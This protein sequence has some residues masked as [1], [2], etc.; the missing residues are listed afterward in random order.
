MD[1]YSVC[2]PEVVHY[3]F[4][5][6]SRGPFAVVATQTANMIA[7]VLTGSVY[8]ILGGFLGQFTPRIGLGIYTAIHIL[9]LVIMTIL[10]FFANYIF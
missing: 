3:F 7:W 9:A 5:A 10:T 6:L 1:P 2:L 4:I 8:G